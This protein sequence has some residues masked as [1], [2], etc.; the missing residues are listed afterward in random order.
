MK[1]GLFLSSFVL[2]GACVICG[3][4]KEEAATNDPAQDNAFQKELADAAAKNG[5]KSAQTN[6]KRE[7]PPEVTGKGGAK[8]SAKAPEEKPGADGASK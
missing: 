7:L 8:P 6:M 2:L 4:N 5:G 1:L 3:C